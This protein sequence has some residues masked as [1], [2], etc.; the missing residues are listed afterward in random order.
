MPQWDDDCLSRFTVEAPV[1]DLTACYV[2]VAWGEDRTRPL[3]IGKSREP[4]GRI[5][6]HLREALWCYEVRSFDFYAFVT[7]LGALDAEARAI[8]ELNPIHNVMRGNSGGRR[9][10]KITPRRLRRFPVAAF[11]A[12]PVP[13]K[14]RITSEQLAIVARVQ[15]RG[16]V[17]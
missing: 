14:G 2:Y 10:R 11:Q 6:R 8:R 7:E 1:I 15:K 16:K 12:I 17:A 9:S 3:Y 4:I 13:L 5:G